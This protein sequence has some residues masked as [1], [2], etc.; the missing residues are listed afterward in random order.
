MYTGIVLDENSRSQLIN[1][2][3]LPPD[4]ELICH[5]MTI[6]IGT[7]DKG[8]AQEYLGQEVDLCVKSV[9]VDDK[10]LAV[11]VE[12]EVPS[13]NSKKHITI[14]VNRKEGGKPFMANKLVVWKPVPKEI[15]LSGVV[16]E[17][18]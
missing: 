16:E 8:P 2:F 15:H 12:T 13:V 11:G 7:A 9:A 10:V 18:S 6:N 17:V 3:P 1:E 4:W 14:A 5:H